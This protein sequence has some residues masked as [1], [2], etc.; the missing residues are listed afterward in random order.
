MDIP[1]GL[2]ARGCSSPVDSAVF[3]GSEQK[4][5][6]VGGGI[7]SIEGAKIALA[8]GEEAVI[9][10]YC[11][12][13]GGIW[14]T[15]ANPESR[16]QVDPVAFRP[17]EDESVVAE[18]DPENPFATIYP[19]R[20]DVLKRLEGDVERFDLHRR[21]VFSV[22]VV[23]FEKLVGAELVRVHMRQAPAAEGA[24]GDGNNAT[25]HKDF[26]QVHIRTGSLTKKNHKSSVTFRGE[27]PPTPLS[28]QAPAG[29]EAGG[30]GGAGGGF[31]QGR[32]VKGIAN[33][34][35]VGEFAGQDV[36]I[37][38]LGAFAVENARRALQGGAKS[39]SILSR[40]FD[41]LLFPELATYLL[42]HRLQ[43]EVA[44]AEEQRHTDA[45]WEEVFQVVQTGT[46]ATGMEGVVLNPATVQ[47]RVQPLAPSRFTR[48][49]NA[50]FL[51]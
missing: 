14:C 31:F 13:L 38:G 42:R 35:P 22:E 33:D 36:V 3:A 6:F 46:R 30:A 23:R 28:P 16:I 15:A 41:K 21:V 1:T 7:S 4:V 11:N 44:P 45:M 49:S 47:A 18:P 51:H 50:H 48:E 20:W 40:K 19:S 26:K 43:A 25:F 8:G 24:G 17:I 39:I 10:E 32:V 2:M 29:G 34:L 37:V 9:V 5:L 27:A 12:F